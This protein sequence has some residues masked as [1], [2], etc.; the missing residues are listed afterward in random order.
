MSSAAL[1]NP[2]APAPPVVPPRPPRAWL[3][4]VVLD[5]VGRR[6]SQLGL[7]WIGIVAICAVFAPFLASSYPLAVKMD[8][9]WSSPMLRHLTPVD[10][11]LL[12]FVLL[13]A[14]FWRWQFRGFALRLFAGALLAA[15][16]LSALLV[17]PPIINV[18]DTYREAQTRG[19]VQFALRTL[20]P[21][22]P[23]DHCW[24]QFD[25]N[26]PPPQPPS[27]RHWLGS[28]KNGSDVLARIIHASRSAM[29]IGFIATGI[30]VLIGTTV[31]ALMGYFVGIV[32]LLGMRL[33]E[34]FSSIPTFYLILTCVAFF[35]RDIYMIV[36]I[37][38]LTGWVEDAR[39]TRAEFLK[40]RQ[41]DF[42]VAARA[43]GLPLWS[44]LF[45]H[46]LPNG[47]APVLVSASF[48]IASAVFLEASL[49]FLG[50][51]L[52]DQPSWGELLN[53]AVSSTGGF[54]WYLATFPGLAIFLTVF[55]Y[56]LIGEALRDAID[57]HSKRVSQ[58]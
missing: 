14:V 8:G 5:T 15:V 46:M 3:W 51:G 10:V 2:S 40:L 55:A 38:G 24:D 44:I 20:I 47:V 57:P 25:E 53:Q 54:R 56:N 6:G 31:G 21:Y 52:V 33:I 17:R 9:Q 45:R 28:D 42:V 39:F 43:C 48:G 49:S 58:L 27:G 7:A 41:Q 12:S 22:S 4:Q 32:D 26:A 16:G 23:S 36:V 35:G 1:A 11:I 29:A 37:I 34:I 13:A 19:R 18:Y 50:V 30:A